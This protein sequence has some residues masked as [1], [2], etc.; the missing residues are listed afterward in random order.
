MI[1][2]CVIAA[3]FLLDHKIKTW[4]EQNLKKGEKKKIGKSGFSFQLLH[5][6]GFAGSHMREHPALVKTVHTIVL[7]ACGIGCVLAG[8]FKRGKGL[9]SFGV[10]LM[11]GGGA[12]NL[13]DRIKK[14]YVVD[15]L[16]LPIAKKL[17]FNLSD[18]CIFAGTFFVFLGELLEKRG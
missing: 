2:V 3:V 5:N 8:C 6:S 1:W 15:Y 10:S 16:G 9:T 12:S 11:L 14:D 18:L 7:L 4:A 13:Y 17:V